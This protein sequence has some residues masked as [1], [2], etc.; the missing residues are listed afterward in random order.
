MLYIIIVTSPAH[1]Y[2]FFNIMLFSE[3]LMVYG[4]SWLFKNQWVCLCDSVPDGHMKGLQVA[5]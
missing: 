2:D 5:W 4:Q 3:I 1:K